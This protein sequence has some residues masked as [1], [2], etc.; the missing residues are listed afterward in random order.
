MGEYDSF[1]DNLAGILK[2]YRNPDGKVNYIA[3]TGEQSV[4]RYAESLSAF[5][6]ELLKTREEKLAFWINCYNA[7]SIYGVVKKIKAD[8][9]FADYGHGSWF[10]RVRFFALQKFVVGGKKWTLRGIENFI[11][12]EFKDPRIHFALNCATTGCPLLKDGLYSAENLD[13]ELDA[14]TVLYLSSPEG[15]ELDKENRTLRVSMVFKWYKKDFLNTG[16]SI[17]EYVLPYISAD[18]REFIEANKKKLKVKYLEY[19]WRLNI[20]E[21]SG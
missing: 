10:T 12:D 16:K 11:R 15:L 14:A 6:V 5:D 13:A 1:G 7:L 17:V 9:D 4:V 21:D 2:R 18:A 20:T 19:G 8:P 3:L